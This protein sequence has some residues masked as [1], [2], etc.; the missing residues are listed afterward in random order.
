ML[1]IFVTSYASPPHPPGA[2]APA[3]AALGVPRPLVAV[4]LEPGPDVIELFYGRNLR[5][6]V[7]R[8][9]V[10]LCQAF[11][12]QSDVCQQSQEPTYELSARK[13][14]HLD[15]LWPYQQ[16]L[17]QAGKECHNKHSCLFRESVNYGP[18]K[19]YKIGSWCQKRLESNP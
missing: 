1:P 19:F 14:L 17:D 10:C 3:P 5:I 2:P 13:V 11:P 8:Q 7:I 12:V 18:K 16:T 6:F 15:R 4:Y 9:S